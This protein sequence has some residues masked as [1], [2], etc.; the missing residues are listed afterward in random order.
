MNIKN[1]GLSFNYN[2]KIDE[3]AKDIFHG[4]EPN[5]FPCQTQREAR[6]P[7]NAMKIFKTYF[8]NTKNKL[9]QDNN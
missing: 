2:Q 5:Q 1:P 6:D 8:N 7:K 3:S 4:F 9:I